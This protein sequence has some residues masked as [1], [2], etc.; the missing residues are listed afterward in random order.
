MVEVEEAARRGGDAEVLREGA[1]I[2]EHESETEGDPAAALEWVDI[3]DSVSCANFWHVEYFGLEFARTFSVY[4]CNKIVFYEHWRPSLIWR[5]Y[6]LECYLVNLD[7]L[8][9]ITSG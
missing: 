7:L 3:C 2:C 8:S 6:L 9:S 5:K 4:I 1:E